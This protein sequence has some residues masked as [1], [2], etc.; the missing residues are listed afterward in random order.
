MNKTSSRDVVPYTVSNGIYVCV[1]VYNTLHFTYTCTVYVIW[2]VLTHTAMRDHSIP[3]VAAA[4]KEETTRW[5][6]W[7]R[8]KGSGYWIKGWRAHTYTYTQHKR[9]FRITTMHLKFIID[10]GLVY[11]LN[12]VN[13]WL[14]QL[15]LL[16]ISA[17][18]AFG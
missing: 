16:F 8:R 15:L 1:C 5:N 13:W 10:R 3:V 4:G 14:L 12:H 11:R 9:T 18:S 2:N 17:V 6:L 7:F